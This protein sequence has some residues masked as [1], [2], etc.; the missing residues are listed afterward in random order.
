VSSDQTS[1]RAEWQ[2]PLR[3]VA[4][5]LP[6]VSHSS[7]PPPLLTPFSL[8]PSPQFRSVS[9]C[10][11]LKPDCC[12]P[13]KTT[14]RTAY[15]PGLICWRRKSSYPPEI[16]FQNSLRN[17]PCNPRNLRATTP[18]RKTLSRSQEAVPAPLRLPSFKVPRG[19]AKLQA[20]PGASQSAAD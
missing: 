11:W 13:A 7:P 18:S 14:R 9:H 19:R 3:P 17:S 10:R 6:A 16:N 8:L 4:L 20:S 1:A 12:V 2:K 15:S 5:P